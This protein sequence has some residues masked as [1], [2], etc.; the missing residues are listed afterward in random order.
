MS[1]LRVTDVE[2]REILREAGVAT[3]RKQLAVLADK[4]P[5][6]HP[7]RNILAMKALSLKRG[8]STIK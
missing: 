3:T 7:G 4:L 2:F 1:V 8:E 6:D 5:D